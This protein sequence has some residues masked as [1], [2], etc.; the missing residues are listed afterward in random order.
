MKIIVALLTLTLVGC[1]TSNMWKEPYYEKT[2]T[3]KETLHQFLVSEDNKQLILIGEKFHYIFDQAN[4]LNTILLS[5]NRNILSTNLNNRNF[6]TY[7]NKIDADFKIQCDGNDATK[8]QIDWLIKNGFKRERQP[9]PNFIFYKTF[10]ITGKRYLSNNFLSTETN[11]LNKKYN[12]EVI[13]FTKSS[14]VLAKTALTPLMLTAEGAAYLTIGGM[15][16]IFSPI[17][18]LDEIAKSSKK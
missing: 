1:A 13:E 6:S 17:I 9:P 7:N 16:V 18:L 10:H 8:K 15:I 4:E 11:T 3:Y 5:E 14:G 2:S 12:I